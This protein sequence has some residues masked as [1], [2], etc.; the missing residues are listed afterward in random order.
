MTDLSAIR[1]L[2]GGQTGADEGGLI[3]ARRFGITTCGFAPRGFRREDG[4]APEVLRGFGLIEHVSADYADRTEANVRAAHA[5]ILFGDTSS[6]GSALTLKLAARLGIL[7][8][9]VDANTN[10]PAVAAWI[11]RQ[12]RDVPE[13]VL[14]IAGN[15]ESASPGICDRVTA[16]LA[17]VFALLGFEPDITEEDMSAPHAAPVTPYTVVIDTREQ[18]PYAFADRLT[19][20]RD[21]VGVAVLTQFAALPSGDYSLAGLQHKVAVERKSL[22]DLYSTLGSGRA[23]F[24]RELARLAEMELAAVVVEA[25]WSRVLTDPPTH[26]QLNPKTIIFSVIAW[27]VRHPRVHWAFLPGREVAEAYT[28]RLL[29][30]FWREEEGREAARIKAANKET[31]SR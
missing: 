28:I 15:R 19:S 14:M 11:A 23:R 8:V 21:P 18:V 16:F 22:A 20:S 9:V 31:N 2:S 17:D 26:S 5:I 24:T 4:C 6:P 7:A 30:R 3:A 29:D 1:I 27:Q 13:P 10:A 25:E 12:F